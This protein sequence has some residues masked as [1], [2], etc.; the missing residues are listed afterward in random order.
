MVLR[1]FLRTLAA[2]ALTLSLFGPVAYAQTDT[3][4]QAAGNQPTGLWLFTDYPELTHPLG[5]DAKISITLKNSNLP[6]ERVQ[7]SVQGLPTG[8]NWKLTGGSNEVSA[9]MV[10]PNETRDLVLTVTPPADAATDTPVKFNVVAQSP[11]QSLTLPITLRLSAAE[12][13]KL[14]LEP[15]L[16]ALRGTPNSSFD[17]QVAIKNESPDDATVNLIA[18]APDGFTTT[19]KEQYGSQELTSLPIKAGEIEDHKG[20]R[21]AGA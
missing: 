12:P 8:W 6:P 2:L 16:P 10:G 17:F 9:A 15:E 5:S 13:A 3:S 20:L 11:D 19:F 14:T 18:T 7:L 1:F 21:P 4:N